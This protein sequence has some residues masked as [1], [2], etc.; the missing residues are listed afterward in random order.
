M[1]TIKELNNI[2]GQILLNKTE[3]SKKPLYI[4]VNGCL[5]QIENDTPVT[6]KTLNHRSYFAI[7]I[8]DLT[9]FLS[10]KL[11]F[12]ES[13]IKQIM[14]ENNYSENQIDKYWKTTH[15]WSINY[16]LSV[17]QFNQMNIKTEI[18]ND[19]KKIESEYGL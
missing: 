13:F 18:L 4:K 14:I 9:I 3:L 19:I 17:R 5:F 10:E 12:I 6:I 8:F 11:F 2:D 1:K 7:N 15:K 16:K